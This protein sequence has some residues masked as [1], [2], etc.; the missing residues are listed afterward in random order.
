MSQTIHLQEIGQ[1]AAKPAKDFTVG[2][3]AVWNAGFTSEVISVAS[4]VRTQITWKVRT[5]DGKLWDRV[6]KADRLVAFSDHHW[7]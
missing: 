4:K 2:D 3:F 6:V 5:M 7:R 1:V